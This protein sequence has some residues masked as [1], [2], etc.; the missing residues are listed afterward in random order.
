MRNIFSDIYIYIYVSRK[1][2]KK[3]RENMLELFHDMKYFMKKLFLS[4][5]DFSFILT[6][7]HIIIFFFYFN[8][9]HVDLENNEV[10][11]FL[12]YLNNEESY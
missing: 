5:C 12:F 7:E 2:V 9:D 3:N 4:N 1:D 6:N 8:K 10:P 11:F